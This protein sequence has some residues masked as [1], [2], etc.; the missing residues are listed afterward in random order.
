MANIRA[1]MKKMMLA[2]LADEQAF[3]NWNYTEARPNVPEPKYSRGK[4]IYSDCSKGVQRIAR[5]SKAPDPM[6]S[7]WGPW[8]NSQTIW[9]Q[10]HHVDRPDQLDVGDIITFGRD[11]D[12]HAA[13]VLEPGSDPLLWSDGHQGAPNTY[14]LAQDGRPAQYCQQPIAPYDPPTADILRSKTTWFAWVAWRLG[15]GPW[16]PYGKTNPQVRPNVPKL[17]PPSWWLRLAKFLKDRKKGN[18]SVPSTPPGGMP[19]E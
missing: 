4:R 10:A 8:G 13:M 19:H 6:R 12:Q 9:L 14:R 3:S 2:T 1:A 7:D 15:E 11:G 5:W 18:P 17:I 16:K